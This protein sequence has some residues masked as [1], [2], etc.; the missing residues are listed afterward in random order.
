VVPILSFDLEINK[1][2]ESTG[3]Y[4][5]VKVDLVLWVARRMISLGVIRESV[6]AVGEV[7]LTRNLANEEGIIA[8]LMG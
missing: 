1:A 2:A 6:E 5:I 3:V 4:V 8:R 7:G